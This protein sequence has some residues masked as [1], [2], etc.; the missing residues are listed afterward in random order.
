MQVKKIKN[1]LLGQQNSVFIAFYTEGYYHYRTNEE[2]RSWGEESWNSNISLLGVIMRGD[3]SLGFVGGHVDEGETLIQAAVREAE[4]EVGF[5]VSSDRLK[6][7]CSH[8]MEK[9][10]F[11]QNTHLYTCKVTPEEMY[12]IQK[13]SIT[14]LHHKVEL[15]GF[16]VVHMIDKAVIHLEN[17]EWAGTGWDELNLFLQSD[18]IKKHTIE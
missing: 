1:E 3:G 4:E 11:L 15:A 12:E 13:S 14:S 17:S 6:I 8:E 18:I 16:N 10:D 9:D 5:I 2:C 7:F